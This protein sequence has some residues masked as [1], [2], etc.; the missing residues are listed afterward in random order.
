MQLSENWARKRRERHGFAPN[1]GTVLAVDGYVVEI[2]KPTAADLDGQE[3][4]CYRNQKDFWGL[5][6][7]VGC[8]FTRSLLSRDSQKKS[9]RELFFM[10][11]FISWSFLCVH[12]CLLVCRLMCS[13][14]LADTLVVTESYYMY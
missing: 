12:V 8:S 14:L 6:T 13:G 3:V 7:Q 1:M 9:E 4:L 11:C 10:V 5:I 2:K